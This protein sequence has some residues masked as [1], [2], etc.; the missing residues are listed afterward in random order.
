MEKSETSPP[1]PEIDDEE[2]DR[3]A[4][5]YVTNT[6]K[7][8]IDNENYVLQSMKTQDLHPETIK[9]QEAGI[10]ELERVRKRFI[11]LSIPRYNAPRT[12]DGSN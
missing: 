4:A 5:I 9:V 10:R 11:P 8:V 2:V 3:R 12:T 1:Y 6:L 7:M